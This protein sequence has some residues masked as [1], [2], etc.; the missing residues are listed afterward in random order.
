M[1]DE[2]GTGSLSP[3]GGDRLRDPGVAPTALNK[4]ENYYLSYCRPMGLKP[5]TSLRSI[6]FRTAVGFT[7][8]WHITALRAFRSYVIRGTLNCCS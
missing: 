3:V 4:F 5:N 6:M 1:V 7:L 2:R 8:S